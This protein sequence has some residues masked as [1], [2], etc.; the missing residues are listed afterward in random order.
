MQ[1]TLFKSSSKTVQSFG[2]F[3]LW[4]EC[5]KLHLNIFRKCWVL[6]STYIPLYFQRL[7]KHDCKPYLASKKV[8]SHTVRDTN[9]WWRIL[10]CQSGR[11]VFLQCEEK[12]SILTFPLL[13]Y[14]STLPWSPPFFLIPIDYIC[15]KVQLTICISSEKEGE[16]E[17]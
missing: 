2:N 15:T 17:I 6:Q 12:I 13:K 4:W 9:S 7:N 5:L 11:L 8:K 14:P 3:Y 10:W 1:S 16:L